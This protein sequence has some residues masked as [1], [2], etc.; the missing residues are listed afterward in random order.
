VSPRRGPSR[1]NTLHGGRA[2]RGVRWCGEGAK[3]G[4]RGEDGAGGFGGGAR[5]GGSRGARGRDVG[6]RRR[7]G[8]PQRREVAADADAADAPG[9][10]DRAAVPAGAAVPGRR[11]VHAAGVRAAVRRRHAAG[12]AQP[13]GV[14]VQPNAGEA[15]AARGHAR[16]GRRPDDGRRTGRPGDAGHRRQWQGG[17]GGGHGRAGRQRG[18]QVGRLLWEHRPSQL[19]QGHACGAQRA[20]HLISLV[21]MVCPIYE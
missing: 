2:R 17:G 9:G 14:A 8:G 16:P 10:G 19:A 20:T 4:G 1:S 18:A 7:R 3:A 15:E 6:R 12:A 5:R 21:D 13:V 11:R